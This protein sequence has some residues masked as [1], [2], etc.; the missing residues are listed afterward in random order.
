M[1]NSNLKKVLVFGTFDLFHE[2]HK[3]FLSEAKKHGSHLTVLIA[4]DSTVKYMK[5]IIP[6]DNE[7]KRLKNIEDS[8]IA[9]EVMLGSETDY[10]SV[11]SKI[12][13]DMICLGYDQHAFVNN[14]DA[15][16]ESRGLGTKIIKIDS[17]APHKYKSTILRNKN[18]Q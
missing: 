3:Y 5:G 9:D 13:P 14:L 10:Y 11:L 1:D 4:R 8:T 2:G 6:H 16:I 7:L 15:E 18:K 12:K 17:H